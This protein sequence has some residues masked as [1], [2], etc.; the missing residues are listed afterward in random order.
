MDNMSDVFNAEE[1]EKESK[2][3]GLLMEAYAH[4]HEKD[5]VSALMLAKEALKIWPSNIDA[6]ALEIDLEAQ[7]SVERNK[8]LK[9][10]ANK[11]KKDLKKDGFFEDSIGHFWRRIDTRPYMRTMARY[12]NA[13][14]DCGM[15]K[16]AQEEI[17]EMLR[18]NPNDNQG[19]RYALMHLYAYLENNKAADRLYKEY[20]VERDCHESALFMLPLAVL[21]FK[22]GNYKKA[23][24]ILNKLCENNKDAEKFLKTYPQSLK[25]NEHLL[26]NGYYRANDVTSQMYV[27]FTT[28]PL[29]YNAVPGFIEWMKTEAII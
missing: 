15:Y 20:I 23:K 7:T 2:S 11:V 18:L 21:E 8:K 13:L 16:K 17:E 14:I 4:E 26:V 12:V 5:Y 27:T 25:E 28:Y 9:R 19:M 29:L 1:Y 24:S 6:K 22:Q 3:D 10:F